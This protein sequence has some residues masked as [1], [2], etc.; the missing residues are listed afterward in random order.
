MKSESKGFI[1]AILGILVVA[2]GIGVFIVSQSG[3]KTTPTEAGEQLE[4][5]ETYRING[6]GLAVD[7]NGKLLTQKGVE[8]YP[9]IVDIYQ[10]YLCSHCADFTELNEVEMIR[11]QQ[12][13]PDEVVYVYHILNFMDNPQ[14]SGYSTRAAS[15]AI[16]VL[17]NEAGLFNDF[18][19]TLFKNQPTNPTALKK[20]S[21]AIGS[22]EKGVG[23]SLLSLISA[24]HY[25]DWVTAN[26]VEV[27]DSGKIQGTPAVFINGQN[28][29]GSWQDP[30]VVSILE[31]LKQE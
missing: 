9:V 21:A 19:L 16:T 17:T 15:A 8:A 2:I 1:F 20:N 12:A 31:G 27:F 30:G 6:T 22:L 13:N 10:D 4:V 23:E 24:E 28:I 5:P 3:H 11:Y 26:T 18:N 14:T 7:A 29:G 25:K